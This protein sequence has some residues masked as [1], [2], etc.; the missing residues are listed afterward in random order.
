MQCDLSFISTEWLLCVYA[1]RDVSGLA[2]AV[3]HCLAC[4]YQSMPA[5]TVLRIWDGL[6]TESSKLLFRAALAVFK[7]HEE[8]IMAQRSVADVRAS[9]RSPWTWG[10]SLKSS[11]C[12]H[13]GVGFPRC[14]VIQLMRNECKRLYNRSAFMT[15][16]YNVSEGTCCS[17]ACCGESE[18][19][20]RGGGT[21]PN[22]CAVPCPLCRV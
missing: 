15:L 18:R 6:F 13:G 20:G 7:T 22:L 14:Q 9:L 2:E 21:R 12:L 10:L 17:S 4:E 19:G 5:M 1:K 11:P 3:L 16:A 8:L